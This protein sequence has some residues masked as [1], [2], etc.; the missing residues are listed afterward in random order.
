MPEAKFIGDIEARW[1]S[2]GRNM[3]LLKDV[4]FVDSKER[5]WK[6]PK[7][8]VIDGASIPRELWS[9]TGSPFVGKYRRASVLHDVACVERSQKHELVHY[10]FYEA[11][12]F[13]GVEKGKAK[14]MYI[15]VREMGPKWDENGDD[16]VV[17]DDWDM[18]EGPEI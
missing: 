12:L 5:E 6:A 8:S 16:L 17:E 13:D 4:V 15:A 3:Q 1:L 18:D 14:L 9:M 7:G 10:M 11:M 2:D